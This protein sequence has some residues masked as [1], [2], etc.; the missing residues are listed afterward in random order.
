MNDLTATQQPSQFNGSQLVI[1]LAK[2]LKLVA[3]ISMS[4]DAQTVWLQAAIDALEDIRPH[5]V[6]AV[7]LEIRRSI[8][9]PCQI[10]PEIARLVA[11][12]REQASRYSNVRPVDLGPELPKPPVPALTAD[13]IRRMPKWLIETGLRVGYL[14]REGDRI[15]D[16]AA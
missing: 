13:E 5:E 14:K 6:A 8:T 12:K 11:E 16:V 15:V 2:M 3:P 7:S 10:V 9:R 1:E 4:A